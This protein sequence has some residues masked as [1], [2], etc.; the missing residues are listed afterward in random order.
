MVLFLSQKFDV[1]VMSK[2]MQCGDS[3]L[4]LEI[5][6]LNGCQRI[7]DKGIEVVTNTCPKLKVFS[8]YWNVRYL[9][10]DLMLFP[11]YYIAVA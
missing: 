7:S 6:N 8:I 9:K 10:L 11:N 4:D 5:L 3:L 1:P 2:N